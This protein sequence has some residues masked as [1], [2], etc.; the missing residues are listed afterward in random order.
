MFV[1][2]RAVFSARVEHIE[3]LKQHKGGE[4]QGLRLVLHAGLHRVV[5]DAQRTDCH[6]HAVGRDF[7]QAGHRQQWL[8][9]SSR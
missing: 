6:G 7:A 8:A 3:K 2:G 4:R 5:Q 9:A 1:E